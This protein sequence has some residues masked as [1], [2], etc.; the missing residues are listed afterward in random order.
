MSSIE[1]CKS[2][3]WSKVRTK[4]GVQVDMVEKI[5]CPKCGFEQDEG[6]ECMRCGVI[7]S[8][9]RRS[10]IAPPHE[11]PIPSPSRPGKSL[12]ARF[13]R[14]Y[15]VFRWVS[16]IMVLTV[17]GLILKDSQPPD[18]D[19]HPYAVQ[20]AEEKVREFQSTIRQNLQGDLS[21]DEAE[22]NGWLDTNLV[23]ADPAGS[24][25]SDSSDLEPNDPFPHSE[26]QEYEWNEEAVEKAK[27]SIRDIRVDLL[28]D[29]LRL[30]AIFDMHGMDLSLELEARL[31]IENGSL[32]LIPVRGKL[33]SLPLP[34]GTLARA[35]KKLYASPENREKFRL[36]PYIRDMKIESG[37]LIVSSREM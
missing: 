30:Y 35:M 9:I 14:F 12:W 23:F 6:A 13:G 18:I 17:A 34:S 7:F 36:P 16:L 19:S 15:R 10:D 26:L 29:T 8:R 24:S 33:G 2:G 31:G 11:L 32:R 27:S 5:E 37:Q 1:D 20:Q 3:R 25:V 4:A 28:D 22:L 21:M